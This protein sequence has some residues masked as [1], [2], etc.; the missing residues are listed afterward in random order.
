MLSSFS[1]ISAATGSV[2]RR[3]RPEGIWCD[4]AFIMMVRKDLFSLLAEGWK[5]SFTQLVLHPI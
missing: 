2:L 5:P 4:A 3:C 1:N